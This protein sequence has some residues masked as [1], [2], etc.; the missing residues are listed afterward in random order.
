MPNQ[1][2]AAVDVYALLTGGV[3]AFLCVYA[4]R[5]IRRRRPTLRQCAREGLRCIVIFAVMAAIWWMIAGAS[6]W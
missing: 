1:D 3:L 4:I 6:P 2:L 5:V